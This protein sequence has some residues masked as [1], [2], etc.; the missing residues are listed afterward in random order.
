MKAVVAAARERYRAW[1][2]AGL[3]PHLRRNSLDYYYLSIWPGLRHLSPVAELTLPP[4]PGPLRYAYLHIPF[5]SGVCDF[6]SYVL[7]S[8]RDAG[9][10]PRVRRYLDQVLDQVRL[11]QRQT[12][13]ELS[14]IYIG[15][16]TPSI[17]TPPQ[18]AYL[19]DT[20]ADLGA[21]APGLSGTMELHPEAFSDIDRLDRTLEILARHGIARVS[22][23]YQSDDDD[24]L[25]A[26]NR[27]HGAGFLATAAGHLRAHG[28]LFNVDLMYGLPGQGVDDF[29]ASLATVLAVRPD[30][31]STYFTFVDPGTRLHHRVRRDPSLLASTE[32]AQL[33]HLV[34]QVALEAAGYYE[35]PNDFYARPADDPADYDQVVLPSEANSLA[36]GAGA[37]GYYPGVQYFNE[38]TFAGYG[39]SI[40]EGR[41]PI[42]RAAVLGPDEELARDT[43]FSFK[44]A[45][46]LSLKLFRQRHGT[47]P[48][49]AFPRQFEELVRLQLVDVGA[50]E[51]RLTP[52]GRL[53]VEE[54]ACLFA[55][56]RPQGSVASRVEENLVR[57]HHFA[58][59]YGE[60]V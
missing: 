41:S 50:D 31:I 47:D 17:L 57:K 60:G 28:F 53:V 39:R 12:S 21:F 24:L 27:R 33:C 22:I 36:L 5:C 54:I 37:Y 25:D 20:M 38:V 10:D 44:N 34:A 32:V 52:K 43:M 14:S 42:W 8:T 13:V 19:L 1:G 18:L 2:L 11:Q 55:P 9:T 48:V 6:C 3:P 29:A 49:Q 58:P 51:V 40:G 35:L 4:R 26:T 23:G 46:L 30:S 56:H 7:T 15:G 59:T 45:P 16:G